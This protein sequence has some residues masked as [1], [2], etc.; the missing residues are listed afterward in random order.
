MK[1]MEVIQILSDVGAVTTGH[2][3]YTSRKHGSIY[4]NKDVIYLNVEKTSNL[5]HAIAKHFAKEKVET[6]IAPATGGIVLSEWTARHLTEMNGQ[7]VNSV[8]AD[9]S[10]DGDVFI[11]KNSY[12]KLI[13]NKRILVVEDILN[14]GG[15]AKKVIEATRKIGGKVIGLGAIC[16]RGEVIEKDVANVPKIFSLLKLTLDAWE[17]K[18]CPLCKKDIP[19]SI[20]VGKG[21]EFLAQKRT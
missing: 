1:E 11:I 20:E 15:S 21:K 9:K 17:E 12:E 4:V 19:I 14:T 7:S 3:V 5:C 8:Y 13:S 16:N 10:K 2:F 18:D 6:V